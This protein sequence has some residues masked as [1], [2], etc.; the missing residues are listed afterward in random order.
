MA[1][2]EDAVPSELVGPHVDVDKL[3]SSK[4]A[5][6]AEDSLMGAWWW[7]VCLWWGGEGGGDVR[8]FGGQGRPAQAG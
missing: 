4:A 1:L 3:V 8:S 5:C 7:G 6:G 2:W